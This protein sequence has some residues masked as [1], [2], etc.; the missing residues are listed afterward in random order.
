MEH[1]HGV[2][3]GVAGI[4]VRPAALFARD[5][6]N[7]VSR[8]RARDAGAASAYR[9][10]ERRR[11]REPLRAEATF[12][13]WACA[14]CHIKFSAPCLHPRWAFF[15]TGK[16]GQRRRLLLRS[17]APLVGK[18]DSF[19]RF[20]S[21]NECADEAGNHKERPCDHQPVW[22]LKCS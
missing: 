18:G 19:F 16:L 1:Y 13:F 9:A 7:A 20:P 6:P 10:G 2:A 14:R 4:R 3:G 17:I 8:L 21:G 5:G 11:G 15:R 22:R 12:Y